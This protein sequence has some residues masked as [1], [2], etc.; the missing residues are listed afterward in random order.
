LPYLEDKRAKTIRG[1]QDWKIQDACLLYKGR[2]VVLKDNNLC[3]KLFR[4]IYTAFNTTH[5]GKTKTF[6]LIA[7]RYY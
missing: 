6:Q 3:T 2:L 4:F 1:D 5:L 7:L